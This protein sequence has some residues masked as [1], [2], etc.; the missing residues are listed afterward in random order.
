M[1]GSSGQQRERAQWIDPGAPF[2]LVEAMVQ[3]RNAL[4]KSPYGLLARCWEASGL[5]GLRARD[6]GYPAEWQPAKAL[7]GFHLLLASGRW[8][9]DPTAEQFGLAGPTAFEAPD[10]EWFV[11]ELDPGPGSKVLGG[12]PEVP[13]LSE[14]AV[15]DLL[16]RW[17]WE[18]DG[19]ELVLGALAA[20]NLEHLRDRVIGEAGLEIGSGGAS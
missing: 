9:F 16:G 10:W 4:A 7:G 14:P 18:W 1:S 12:V 2:E 15:V 20:V 17:A 19:P 11:D 3:I 13:P 8:M 5:L 6:L